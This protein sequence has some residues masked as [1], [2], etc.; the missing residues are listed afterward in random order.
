MKK[1]FALDARQIKPLATKRGGCLATDM[2]TVGG[3]KVGYMVRDKPRNSID[4]G[5]QFFSGEES[6]DYLDDANNLSIYDVNT[7]ANYDPDIIPYLDAPFGASFERRSKGGQFV[8]VAGEPYTA[9]PPTASPARRWPPPGFPLVEGEHVLTS[10]WAIHL[11]E[12]FARRIE[13]GSLVLWRP[14]LTMWFHA[15]RN[16]RGDSQA[17]RLATA[18][19]AASAARFAEREVVTD[20]ITRFDCRLRE[21]GDDGPVESVH[22]MIFSDAGHV[23]MAVYFDDPLDEPKAR[24]LVDSV[25]P[26]RS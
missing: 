22:A 19:A 1:K 9:G 17:Q 7:I 8:Q 11:P 14:G 10:S 23:Q 16:D 3:Q 25:V 24:Q 15:W 13:G 26:R 12:S 5:W 20:R 21:G 18:K 6:Q 4:S 2:I